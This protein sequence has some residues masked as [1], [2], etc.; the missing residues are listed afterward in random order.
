MKR[1]TALFLAAVLLLS[2][3]AC[4]GKDP[5]QE[6]YDLGM[7]YLNEGNY[8]EAIIAFEAA[9]E[10][11][12]KRPEAYL[13]AAEAYIAADDIDAAI[14]IL[15]KGYAATNDDTLKKRLD[16]I[17][18]GTFSDYWG[19]TRRESHYDGNSVLTCWYDYEYNDP[20][21]NRRYTGITSYGSNGEEIQHLERIFDEQ[22]HCVY[23]R[24]SWDGDGKMIGATYTYDDKG[25]RV[26]FV[27]DLN[28]T[29]TFSYDAD[30]K[31]IRTDHYDPNGAST[32]YETYEYGDGYRRDGYR[33]DNYYNAEGVLTSYQIHYYNQQEQRVRYEDYDADGTLTGYATDEYD[34]NGKYIAWN[35]YDA[36]GNLTSRDVY[37]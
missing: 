13:G 35:H 12:A 30:G 27:T 2:L 36:E 34:D 31:L 9:I 22:G 11:D 25:R 24:Y 3:A 14:A 10:I 23:D 37:S 7:R 33:R 20:E 16:E 1:V 19:R 29:T 15:E 17:K 18:S 28:D 5:W 26:K 32:G 21:N 4:G 6:Q 8:Q